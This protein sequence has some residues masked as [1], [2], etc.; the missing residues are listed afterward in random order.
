MQIS[1]N[2]F[3]KY[4]PKNGYILD[5]GSGAGRD[6]KYFLDNDYKIKA[7]TGSTKLCLLAEQY[8]NHKVDN[9][10]FQ[11]LND[12][13]IYERIWCHIYKYKRRNRRRNNKRKIFQILYQ[14]RIY[15]H[16]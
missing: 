15:K 9:M 13:N 1:Y 5:F 11:N 4:I 16:N 2:K 3:L 12:I 8:I 14:R 7:I 6:S 10:K